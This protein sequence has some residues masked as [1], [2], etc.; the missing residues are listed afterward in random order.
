MYKIE[1]SAKETGHMEGEVISP[2]SFFSLF[3]H[4]HSSFTTLLQQHLNTVPTVHMS[5]EMRD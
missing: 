1:K 5:K 3:K 4:T 2:N